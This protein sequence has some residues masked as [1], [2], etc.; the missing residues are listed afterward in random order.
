MDPAIRDKIIT[1]ALQKAR[2][3]LSME[4]FGKRK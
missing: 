3:G 2:Q 1:E 4:Y